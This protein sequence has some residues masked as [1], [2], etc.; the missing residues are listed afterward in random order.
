MYSVDSN[1]VIRELPFLKHNKDERGVAVCMW[2]I[3]HLSYPRVLNFLILST[4]HK[5]GVEFIENLFVSE[6]GVDN[7]VHVYMI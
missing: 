7:I 3:A 5:W 4:L 6:E 1:F 2:L